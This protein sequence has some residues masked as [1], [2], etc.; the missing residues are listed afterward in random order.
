MYRTAE[1]RTLALQTVALFVLTV[2]AV[3]ACRSSADS[4]NSNPE[5]GS[6]STSKPFGD[7]K[8]GTIH[9]SEV[10]KRV[11]GRLAERLNAG[12]ALTTSERRARE[13]MVPFLVL[14]STSNDEFV[15]SQSFLGIS[16]LLE[17]GEPSP[18]E[19]SAVVA[20]HLKSRSRRVR[21]SAFTAAHALM[22]T[23]PD[24]KLMV[25][26]EDVL[27]SAEDSPTRLSA[28]ECLRGVRP[29][30]LS[31]RLLGFANQRLASE[32]VQ[33]FEKVLWLD[34]AL[35]TPR[36]VH[37]FLIPPELM[38]APETRVVGL[39]ALALGRQRR[40]E[41]FS[42][43]QSLLK[44]ESPTVRYFAALALGELGARDKLEELVSLLSDEAEVQTEWTA[45]GLDG[46]A[47]SWHSSFAPKGTQVRYG[48]LLALERIA[49]LSQRAAPL[50]SPGEDWKA[51][52]DAVRT[53]LNESSS[54]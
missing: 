35:S 12:H 33:A 41:V 25:M 43:L 48:A 54:D 36:G 22:A 38:R 50:P 24:Q 3:S 40:A 31:S 28:I 39:A 14:A 45:P 4:T 5:L 37:R 13:H 9:S 19:L 10:E 15:I 21:A 34:V 20:D 6:T 26:L 51:R 18:H 52:S 7:A 42:Q 47:I 30:L 32:K 2:T 49:G 53:K 8:S 44:Q 27:Q 46:R 23:E 1:L 11:A 16:D 17:A 29:H